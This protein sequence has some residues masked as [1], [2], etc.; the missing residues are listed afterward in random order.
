MIFTKGQVLNTLSKI[1]LPDANKSIVELNM[2]EDIIISEKKIS[3]NVVFPKFNNPF[4][5]SIKKACQ[6]ALEKESENKI[7][8]EVN[9]ISK[10]SFGRLDDRKVLP[11]IK[12]IV[13][14]ASGK[15]G[16]GKSTI[17]SNLAVSF[18][19][20]GAKVG[21]I[22]ADIFGPS[23]PK[24]FKVEDIRPEVYK[25]G[26]KT[27]IKP[28]E[29]YGVKMLSIGFFANRDDALV[30]RGPMATSALKQLLFDTDW[31]ELDY[32]F[33]DL[34]PG[35]SD[36]HLTLVQEVPVTGAIIVTTPQEVA[37]IDAIKGINM[38]AG[39]KINV[40][41]L[42]IVENMSWFTPEE[43]PE[44]KYYIFGK[45][46]G[47]ELAKRLKIPFVGQ[48]PIVQGIREGGDNGVPTS[49][50]ENAITTIAFEKL[51]EN[52]AEQIEIRNKTIAPTKKVE[53]SD[54]AGCSAAH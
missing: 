51:A 28:V 32:L 17:S 3:L 2:V 22:D 33:I 20:M 53:M 8:I 45:D 35:T 7:E 41:V 47:M 11:N 5:N 30:W 54:S 39:E 6:K 44:N 9:T 4:K 42:G 10:I 48:I 14:I 38:F 52:I 36:I 40:P 34:P 23:I 29:N 15:G 37:L 49:V 19:R 16:V 46:G 18:A 50:N 12:N 27:R 31:G 13:A 26:E 1:K 43:L 21:L 25:E 24:M